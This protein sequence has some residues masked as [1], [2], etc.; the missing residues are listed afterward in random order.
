MCIVD[1]ICEKCRR[2]VYR[3]ENNRV[4]TVRVFPFSI[5]ILV[6][7]GKKKKMYNQFPNHNLSKYVITQYAHSSWKL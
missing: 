6:N 7:F 1:I 4:G 3:I 2:K 5:K